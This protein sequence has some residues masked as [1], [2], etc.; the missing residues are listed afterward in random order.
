[1][2]ADHPVALVTG[3]NDGIGRAIAAQLTDRGYQVVAAARSTERLVELARETGVHPMTLDVTDGIA[4]PHVASRV[5]DEVGP[6]DRLV[7]N[8]GAAGHGRVS[9]EYPSDDWWRIFEVNVLG[10]FLRCHAV[11]PH[12]TKRGSGRIVNLSSGAATFEIDDDSDAM[13][14]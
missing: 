10:S 6:V 13:I 2:P 1:M 3:A 8:A 12:M 9:W 7:N 4:V 14:N 11:M 5:E